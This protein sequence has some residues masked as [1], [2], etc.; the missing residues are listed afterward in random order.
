MNEISWNVVTDF[1]RWNVRVKNVI[2]VEQFDLAQYRER[3]QFISMIIEDSARFLIIR[4]SSV[5]QE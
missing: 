5:I 1:K 3:R 4:H 2:W